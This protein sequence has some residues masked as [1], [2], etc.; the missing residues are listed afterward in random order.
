M[1]RGNQSFVRNSQN[2]V[3]IEELW[4]LNLVVMSIIKV[5]HNLFLLNNRRQA[6]I[7]TQASGAAYCDCQFFFS[8]GVNRLTGM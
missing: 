3:I 6:A 5:E 4:T 7:S 8:F 2:L 1:P